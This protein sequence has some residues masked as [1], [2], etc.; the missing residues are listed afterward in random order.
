MGLP[1]GKKTLVQIER[2][3]D[4]TRR[5]V[6]LFTLLEW[7]LR[8]APP[9]GEPIRGRPG[10]EAVFRAYGPILPDGE[11]A[12]TAV[13]VRDRLM[14]NVPGVTTPTP[15]EVQ[16][17]ADWACSA[18]LVLLD[19]ERPG[20]DADTV[21]RALDRPRKPRDLPPSR[22]PDLSAIEKSLAVVVDT[23]ESELGW[24]DRPGLKPTAPAPVEAV[25][26]PQPKPSSPPP[27]SAP[28]PAKPASPPPKPVS[29]PPSKPGFMK[30]LLGNV[31]GKSE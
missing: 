12:I 26:P 31:F 25:A 29:P 30:K 27:K 2:R 1:L 11:K 19:L 5:L 18:V 3:T 13:K 20:I 28:Q 8:M 24:A 15:T 23:L 6:D 7:L 4:P 17:S 16:S 10:L 22:R 9:P 14:H 21:V